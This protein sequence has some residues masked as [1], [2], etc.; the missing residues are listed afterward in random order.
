MAEISDIHP[1]P[2]Q[3]AFPAGNPPGNERQ[4]PSGKKPEKALDKDAPRRPED[5]PGRL[6]EHA[7]RDFPRWKSGRHRPLSAQETPSSHGLLIS[8]AAT[9][10]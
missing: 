6:D 10:Y 9:Y 2:S 4:P 1:L 7:A 8:R 3:P 5:G